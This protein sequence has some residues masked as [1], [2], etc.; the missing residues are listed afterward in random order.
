MI[1]TGYLFL[2]LA[3]ILSKGAIEIIDEV[4]VCVWERE[5]GEGGTKSKVYFRRQTISTISKDKPIT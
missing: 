4:C 5:R 1:L 2:N 3:L